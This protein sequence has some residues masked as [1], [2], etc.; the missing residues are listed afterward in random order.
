MIERLD[1]LNVDD[2]RNNVADD[3]DT[4]RQGADP[5]SFARLIRSDAGISGRVLLTE[6]VCTICFVWRRHVQDHL[7]QS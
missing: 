6:K 1:S 7:M 4:A 3:V 2:R 5:A